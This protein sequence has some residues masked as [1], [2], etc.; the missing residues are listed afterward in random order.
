VLLEAERLLEG[1]Q[2]PHDSEEV[3]VA[4]EEDVQPHLDVV[5]VLVHPRPHLAAHETPRL[6]NLYLVPC[7]RKVHGRDHTGQ[8]AAHNRHLELLPRLGLEARVR[9]RMRAVNRLA[10]SS[11]T[12]LVEGPCRLPTRTLSDAGGPFEALSSTRR[13]SRPSLSVPLTWRK[14]GASL[15]P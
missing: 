7:V 1:A 8:P 4:P 5:A 10:W 11:S 13:S 9:S 2:T 12:P 3:V 15:C 6:E 14:E